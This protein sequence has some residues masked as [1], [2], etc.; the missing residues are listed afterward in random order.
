MQNAVMDECPT[1]RR[2]QPKVLAEFLDFLQNHRGLSKAT[3]H[4]RRLHVAPLLGSMKSKGLDDPR[5]ISAAS[6]HDYVI[7][8]AR[9]MSRPKRK[10]LVSSI[11]SFL[12]FLYT[13]GYIERDIVECVPVIRT[14]KL[15]RIP[16]GI[17]WEAVQKVT[18]AIDRTTNSGRREFAILLLL[19]HYGVRIGQ[20][21]TLRLRDI[22][23]RNGL[24]RF[25][26]SKKGNPLCFPLQPD[27]EALLDYIEHARGRKS[28]PEVFL[29]LK[30]TPRPLGENN[31]LNCTFQ[32]LFKRAGIDSPSKGS[33]AFRHAFASRLMERGTPIKVI[34][35]MLGHKCIDTTFIYTKVDLKH[36]RSVASEWPEAES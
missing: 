13:G 3:L 21:T 16:R 25:P 19:T 15:D 31:H 1:K 4:I 10:H 27:V 24:I 2:D 28:F 17:S 32:T 12:R 34:A 9:R 8:T 18:A 36:L 22:D 20:I 30:G 35:D 14:A 29:T 11:R 23:W 7:E 5:T 33:H 6:I 26:I